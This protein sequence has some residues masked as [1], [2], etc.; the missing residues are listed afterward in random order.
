MLLG[1]TNVEFNGG[2]GYGG[3]GSVQS[4]RLFPAPVA[5]CGALGLSELEFLVTLSV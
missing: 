5:A 1:G 3:G 2:P 4:T